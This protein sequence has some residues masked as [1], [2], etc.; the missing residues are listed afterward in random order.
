MLL[1]PV[2]IYKERLF[3]FNSHM[4]RVKSF[5]SLHNGHF[6]SYT[7]PFI[8]FVLSKGGWKY[9]LLNNILVYI[10]TVNF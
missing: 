9:A 6:I 1:V 3:T 7:I 4:E 10:Y 5:K 2:E 8:L